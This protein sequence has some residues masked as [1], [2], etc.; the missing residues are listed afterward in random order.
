MQSWKLANNKVF[1]LDEKNDYDSES[2]EQ[3]FTQM[4]RPLASMKRTM[5]Y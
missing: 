4:F 1:I 2:H 3:S 5:E